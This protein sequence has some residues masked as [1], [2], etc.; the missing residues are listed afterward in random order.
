MAWQL[1]VEVLD[2]APADLTSGELAV[3]VVVAE[4]VRHS[5]YARGSRRCQRP[6]EH[7]ARRARMQP[8]GVK[9]ALQRLADRGLDIR[10]PLSTGR[11]GRP[12]YAVPGRVSVYQVPIL[13]PPAECPCDG[14][15]ALVGE[16]DPT[17]PPSP[18]G[19]PTVPPRGDHRAGKGIP[20]GRQAAPQSPPPGVG[21]GVSGGRTR[22]DARPPDRCT[23]HQNIPPGD[24]VPN[25]HACGSARQT[26]QS[27]DTEQSRAAAQ[28]RSA[29]GRLHATDRAL[30]IAACSICDGDGYVGRVL[31]DHDSER[32]ERA[33]RGMAAVRAALAATAGGRRDA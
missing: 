33:R 4:Y 16:G 22:E 30:A 13:L 20:Q 24:P 10:V 23:R 28:A 32:T 11:D 31:C 18:E 29:D 14:C 9:K 5:D 17:V 27:W 21:S 8:S 6:Q 1:V 2:H 15:S 25:C 12:V 7:V 3:M 26:A 19:G